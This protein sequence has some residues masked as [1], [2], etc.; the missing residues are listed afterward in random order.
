MIKIEC[1]AAFSPQFRF[2]ERYGGGWARLWGEAE[3]E[4]EKVSG[5]AWVGDAV[6]EGLWA[7]MEGVLVGGVAMDGG[8]LGQRL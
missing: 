6:A 8:S 3:G 5:R 2:A 1:A 4:P 7:R